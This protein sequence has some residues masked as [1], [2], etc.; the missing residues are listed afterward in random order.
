MK[1]QICCIHHRCEV[2]INCTHIW[3]QGNATWLLLF[4]FGHH[5]LIAG[6]TSIG[7]DMVDMAMFTVYGV[8]DIRKVLV[9]AHIT[10]VVDNIGVAQLLSC[11]VTSVCIFAQDIDAPV[12]TLGESCCH[13]ETNSTGWFKLLLSVLGC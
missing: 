2:H 13:G 3:L 11:L 9:L 12:G 4:F 6:Y 1:S 8:E 10:L 5:V 7:K